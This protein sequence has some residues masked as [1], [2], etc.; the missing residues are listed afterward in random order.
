MS[1]YRHNN[2]YVP[3]TSS[4]RDWRQRK[5]INRHNCY[6]ALLTEKREEHERPK[7]KSTNKKKLWDNTNPLSPHPH[8]NMNQASPQPIPFPMIHNNNAMD[9]EF[10][11]FVEF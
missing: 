2:F 1:R 5:Q 3:V 4:W 8:P 6:H 11:E 9:I 10:L 7:D